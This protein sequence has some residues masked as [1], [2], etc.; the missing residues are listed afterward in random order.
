VSRV[1]I[2]VWQ[3]CVCG[4]IFC[5]SCEFFNESLIRRFLDLFCMEELGA[6]LVLLKVSLWIVCW[7]YYG[8]FN[9]NG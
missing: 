9:V 2:Y 8:V 6:V 4:G 5:V 7:L 3:V 1:Y